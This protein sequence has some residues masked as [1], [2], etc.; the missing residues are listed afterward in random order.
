MEI[1]KKTLRYIF[2]GAAGCILLYWLLHET[3]RIRAVWMAVSNVLSPFVT[4]AAI[5]FVLNVPMRA[6]ERPLKGIKKQG[7]RRAVAIVLTLLAVGLVLTGVVYLLVPQLIMTIESLIDTIPGFFTKVQ[8]NVTSFLNNNP[9]LFAWLQAN[10]DIENFNWQNLIEK[11]VAVLS[12]G[13][14]TVVDMVKNAIVGLST[15]IFNAVLSIVFALY[16][17]SRKEILARQ[18]RRLVYS[19]LPEPKG[20]EVIRVLRM[21]NSSFSNFISGQC[22]EALILGALFA[23]FMLIFNMPYVPLISVIIAVTA[24]VPI[25]G[26][27]VGCIVGAFFILMVDP[28]LAFW[29]VIMFLILQQ[30]ENNLIYPRVV[31]SSIGLPG[32]WVLLAVAIGG[33][34]MGVGGMLLMIPLAAVV[35]TL[36]REFTEKQLEK[37]GVPQEKL[38]DQP[39]VLK[40][41]FQQRQE[42]KKARK[43]AAAQ[44]QQEKDEEV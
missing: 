9:D 24:L 38:V 8:T 40:S 3:E 42:R 1:N 16:C 36:L 2:L 41:G 23:V 25:V 19:I 6:I 13:V 10:T 44:A 30:L 43:Q 31:G 39:P 29:F 32:M 4:G 22:L 5:A 12:N 17:L 35:Y 14:S 20:D 26:A 15:G 7:L 11:V 33:D 28:Q 27:F 34:L 21:T 37:R 18:G